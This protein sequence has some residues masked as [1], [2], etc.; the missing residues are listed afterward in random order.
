MKLYWSS[1]LLIDYSS[2]K[3][4]FDMKYK[5]IYLYNCCT[6]HGCRESKSYN[7]MSKIYTQK[8][9]WKKL[10]TKIVTAKTVNLKIIKPKLWIK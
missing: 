3:L 2:F 5:H 1:T 8:H 7:V 6:L 10:K 9:T 4:N